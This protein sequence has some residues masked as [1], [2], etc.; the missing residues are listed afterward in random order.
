[1]GRSRLTAATAA[2]AAV[3]ACVGCGTDGGASGGGPGE[4]GG[5]G[6]VEAV[7]T[8]D[9]VDRGAVQRASVGERERRG[10]Q[11]VE[12]RGAGSETEP[13][14]GPATAASA[15]DGISPGA[16]TDAEVRAELRQARRQLA[17]F[18]TF[19]GTTAYLQ[20]GPR[21][22]VLPDG[23]AVAPDDAPEPVKRIIQAGNAI[24]KFPYKWGG[25]HGAWRDDGYDCSGSV[26]FALAGA[27]LL[28]SPLT[29]GGFMDWGAAGP[30]EWVTIYT[31][32]G[33]IFMIV[34]GLRFDTS[35]R[36]RAGTRWQE[37]PRSTAGFVVRSV[38]G[39]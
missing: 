30:G 7:L 1:M 14:S 37:A 4:D 23:T 24:A 25:G 3:A 27:G 17:R 2:L 12:L 22:R 18:R 21:A 35:G 16:P 36:G 38:P 10:G 31:N 20:T 33:H 29:S 5:G 15:A 19:L 6:A 39:L 28:D 34:A 8:P 26:S 11:A 32:P 9:S 13:A